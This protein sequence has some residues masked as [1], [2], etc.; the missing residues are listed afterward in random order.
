MSKMSN[1]A[2]GAHDAQGMSKVSMVSNPC[3][4]TGSNAPMEH[5]CFTQIISLN[6]TICYLFIDSCQVYSSDLYSN[7]PSGLR[8]LH[9]TN[10]LDTIPSSLTVARILLLLCK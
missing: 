4:Y 10:P 1:I 8:S 5:S 3:I 2:H 9:C 7:L 6:T